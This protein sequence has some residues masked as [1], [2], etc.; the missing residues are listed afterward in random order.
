MLLNYDNFFKNNYFLKNK[1]FLSTIHGS[2]GLQFDVSFICGLNNGSI[3]F[4]KIC[5]KNCYKLG[6]VLSEDSLKLL[7]VA[8]SRSKKYLYLSSIHDF[9][10]HETCILNPFY[11]YLEIINYTP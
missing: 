10:T 8:V 4:Y 3:P 7:N 5:Q 9:L 1:I 6:G 11:K 2:K